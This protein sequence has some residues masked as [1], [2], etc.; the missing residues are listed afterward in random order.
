MQ[1]RPTHGGR[2][3]PNL[4]MRGITSV[5]SSSFFQ[6][7]LPCLLFFF[8]FVPRQHHR[9]SVPLL[10]FFLF[11]ESAPPFPFQTEPIAQEYSCP[12]ALK[13]KKNGSRTGHQGHRSEW[14]QAAPHKQLAPNR[15][16]KKSS[17]K[18][19]RKGRHRR[20]RR[21][22]LR[23]RGPEESSSRGHSE[24]EEDHATPHHDSGRR[25]VRR[26]RAFLLSPRRCSFVH[27]FEPNFRLTSCPGRKKKS[28]EKPRGDRGG[29]NRSLS[30]VAA[31]FIP[32]MGRHLLGACGGGTAGGSGRQKGWT[33]RRQQK[34]MKKS[35]RHKRTTDEP[36]LPKPRSPTSD[37]N[38]TWHV[39]RV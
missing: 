11:G 29:G 20:G 27:Y 10:L 21:G 14:L 34:T 5:P 38:S 6:G 30:V 8:C 31:R 28:E 16:E 15:R 18:R 35:S 3:T 7:F 36:T 32:C 25:R 22:S 23:Q 1:A 39:R 12:R 2:L 24:G 37:S 33:H 19:Q 26:I 17:V 4:M 9:D 13:K